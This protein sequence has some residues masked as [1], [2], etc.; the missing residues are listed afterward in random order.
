MQPLLTP[1]EGEANKILNGIACY[2]RK[3]LKSTL[4][5]GRIRQL[6]GESP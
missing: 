4:C 3:P 1:D 2:A 6:M 5:A